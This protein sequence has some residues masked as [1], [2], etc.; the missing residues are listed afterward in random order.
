MNQHK[1]AYSEITQQNS[2][3]LLNFAELFHCMHLCG[4]TKFCHLC[5]AIKIY[6]TIKK[7]KRLRQGG[8]NEDCDCNIKVQV[9][10]VDG[11]RMGR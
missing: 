6:K 4:P 8:Q 3:V 9:V 11:G 10:E 7:T 2:T 1:H 5:S